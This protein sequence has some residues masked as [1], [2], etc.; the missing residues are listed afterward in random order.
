MKYRFF[1]LI[2]LL[3]SITQGLYAQEGVDYKL[4]M[5]KAGDISALYR[6]KGAMRYAFLHN[7]TYFWDSPE[8]KIGNI[9][10]NGKMYYDILINID[11]YRQDLLI[12]TVNGI[13][14]VSLNEA[15]V[16]QFNMEEKQFVNLRKRGFAVPMG[17]YQEIYN[18]EVAVYK[19]VVKKY[20]D[21]VKT[22][23]STTYIKDGKYAVLR[24]FDAT[25]TYYLLKDG[26]L[27]LLKGKNSLLRNF[28]KETRKRAKRYA[29]RNDLD[30]ETNFDVYCKKV[31]NYIE[32]G[33]EK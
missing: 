5:E 13:S 31:L 2:I 32:S 10:Y 30:I 18:G 21:N 1:L 11:A 15:Y 14:Q 27:T 26:R 9:E 12:K 16:D 24:E 7:G 3:L 33:N 6:G 17:Y 19:Q 4:F 23:S 20:S 22:G 25:M 8:F 29:R 28:D